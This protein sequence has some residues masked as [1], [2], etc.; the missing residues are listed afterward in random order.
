M[1]KFGTRLFAMAEQ[2]VPMCREADVY[3]R[4]TPTYRNKLSVTVKNKQL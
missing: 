2:V 1:V 4:D 3:K